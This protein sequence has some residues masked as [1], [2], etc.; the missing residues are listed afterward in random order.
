MSRAR[1]TGRAFRRSRRARVLLTLAAGLCL[2]TAVLTGANPVS[3][4]SLVSPTWSVSDSTPG[5]T[6]VTYTY[7]FT[8]ATHTSINSVTMTVPTGTTGSPTLISATSSQNMPTNGTIALANDT[9][10]YSFASTNVKAGSVTITVGGLTNTTTSG[11]YTSQIATNNGATQVDTG[12]S[13]SVAISTRLLTS[14]V[15]SVSNSTTGATGASYTYSFTTTTA[16]TLTSVTMSVP[17]GT[18]GT[19]AVGTVTGLPTGSV[20]LTGSTLTYNGFSQSTPA[21]TAVSIQI[22]GLTNTSTAGSYTSL[23]TTSST[24]GTVDSGTTGAVPFT[25]ASLTSPVW[26]L[27]SSTAGATGVA[28][29]YTFTITGATLTSVTMSV[30]AGTTGTPGRG[31]ISSQFSSMPATGT[32]TLA[33]NTLTYTFPS[34]F[35]NGGPVSI[36]VTGLTNTGTPGNYTS[37]IAVNNGPTPVASGVSGPVSISGGALTSPIW[38][39]S[40]TAIGATGVAYAYTFTTATAGTLTSVTMSVP[41]GTAAATPTLG[42]VSGLPGGGSVSLSGTTLTY[43]GF[44]QSTPSGTAISIEI[45]GMTNTSTAGSYTSLIATNSSTGPIDT[46]ST[47]PA[48]FGGGVLVSPIWTSSSSAASDSGVAYTYSFTTATGK[49]LNSVTMTV[50]PGTG[51]TPAVGT[52]SGITAGTVA[53][54]GSTLTYSVSAPTTFV[55]AA[56]NVSIQ[57]TGLTNTSTG[58]SY[59][60]QITTTTNGGGPT[61]PVD[62][63]TTS[64]VAI[65]AGGTLASPIWAV[66]GSVASA[67][68]VSYTYS[69]TTASTATLSSVSMSVPPGTA[70]TPGV[71]TVTGLPT[72]TVTLAS[73]T[74]TYTF[75][76]I[77]VSSGT[78]VSI[79]I[80]GM[81]NTASVGSYT[82]QLVT[83][84]GTIPVDTGTTAP[85]SIS[86]GALTNP[87]WSVSASA[88]GNT[89][90]TYTYSFTTVSGATLSSVTMTVPPGTAAGTSGLGIGAVSSQNGSMP[91]NGTASLA[92]NTITYSFS[93]TF[94]N[95][96]SI[97]IQITGVTNTATPGNYTSQIATHTATSPVDTGITGSVSFSGG[98]LTSPIWTVSS[99]GSLATNVAYTYTFTT[100]SPATLNS[101]SMSVPPGTA[102]TP[103]RGTITGIPG[104]GNVSLGS[105]TLTYDGFSQLVPAGTAVSIQIT[106]MTNTSTDG[107]YTSQ[108]AT[109]SANGPIDSAVTAPVSIGGGALTNPIWSVSTPSAN[110]GA[111]YTYT[112]TTRTGATL[113]SMTMTVPPGTTGTAG[114]PTV[115]GLPAGSATLAGNTLTYTFNTATFVN[116]STAVSVRV[117]G[118]TNTPSPGGYTSQI[119]TFKSNSGGPNIP[120]DSGITPPVTVQLG[121]AYTA[122]VASSGASTVVPLIVGSGAA[123]SPITT[124]TAPWAVAIDPTATTA[125]VANSSAGTLSPVTLS[126]GTA[127]TAIA[128]TGCTTPKAVALTPDGS[129]AYVAC[130]GSGKVVPVT[131]PGGT[132]GT[133]IAVGTTPLGVAISPDG[134]TAYVVNGGSGTLTPVTVSSNTAGAAIALTGCGTPNAVAITPD[135]TKAYVTCS[136]SGTVLPVTLPGGTLGSAIAVGT[137]P[138]AIAI[139]PDGSKAY[140]ANSGSNTVTPITLSGG[141]AGTAIAVG[142]APK[143]VAITPDGTTAYVTNSIANTVTPIALSTNTPGTALA[144]GTAPLGVVFTPDQAPAAAVS[145]TPGA[146]G[147][148]T[149]FDA[150]ASNAVYGTI[151]TYAWSFGDG[152][153]ASTSSPTTTHTYAAGCSY[154]VTVTETTSA[155]TSTARVFTGQ[156]LSRN[157]G[158]GATTS[159]G[160]A[161][162]RALGFVSNPGDLGFTGALNGLNQTLTSTLGLDVGAGTSA[163]GWS[164]SAT[165]TLFSTGGG[166]PRTLPAAAVTVQSS[167]AT[168]CDGAAACT[169]PTNSVSY[170][171]PLPSGSSAPAAT[172]L[173]AANAATGICD[174]TVTPTF[175]LA[176]PSAAYAGSYS[177]TWTF[178]LSSGP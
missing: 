169:A 174:Q 110:V 100:A 18:S 32:V 30:P 121:N 113:N 87:I 161:V 167:P 162:T 153:T 43:S 104:T 62:S 17:A 58:G 137:T 159:A 102:G 21:G 135:G 149:Q 178:T 101:V 103:G 148:P 117:P 108:I 65:S 54:T 82:S 155:G 124:G 13:N 175:S 143:G 85:T 146:A 139:A 106:G 129:K 132:V 77:S 79:R 128:L 5:A 154:T 168:A 75:G 80:N 107:S 156:T 111:T 86:G 83:H 76:A 173:F 70:G 160:F 147:T 78:S 26:S 42:P 3:A 7:A 152:T 145:V 44:S 40:S 90:V 27:S 95:N 170:P 71:G 125:Y 64:A 88:A 81:T 97:S 150:S 28:Y 35:V 67:T 105:N 157:G 127:G 29:T 38:T 109:S 49:A 177:S 33:N 59:T 1:S 114:A 94:V 48:T 55:N 92:A 140:V 37:Q 172:K 16:D 53:L 61:V 130:S 138:S 118:L 171:Y 4:A 131:L 134:S 120:V 141:T 56:T 73:N 66:S 68:N 158:N 41:S 15:W 93:P 96:G 34:T 8:T 19:P 11:S 60:S 69:F 22:T 123:G 74:L 126:T 84:N 91:A 6:G 36:Q 115:T 14:Q 51:G 10:T 47:A 57:I 23:I 164:I 9:L 133:A 176:V 24:S 122:Y 166:T 165:S 112:F 45:D 20:S 50:P 119:T 39:P 63:G 151:A 116:G 144:V 2:A 25:A 31:A 98:T 52:I 89:G 136:G 142:T 46:G 72:G 163:A 12:T 99:P